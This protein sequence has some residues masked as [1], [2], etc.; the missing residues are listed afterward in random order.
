[1]HFIVKVKLMNEFITVATFTYPSEMVAIRGRLESDGI[2]CYV[3]DELT[4]QIYNFYSNAIGGIRLEVRRS[5]Y[6]KA[7][8]ILEETGFLKEEI[9]EPSKFWAEVDNF[10]KNIPV[11]NTMRLEL[12]LLVVLGV[13]LAIILFG[14]LGI[15]SL[16]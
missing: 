3:K 4:V 14:F 6:E 13:S 11:I 1:M 12:R 7:R 8:Q 9:A 5:D 2:E 16:I 10:T 15:L